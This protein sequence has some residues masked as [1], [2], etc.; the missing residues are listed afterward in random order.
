MPTLICCGREQARVWVRSAGGAPAE[1]PAREPVGKNEIR[2]RIS[3]VPDAELTSSLEAK[4]D[5]LPMKMSEASRPPGVE[6]LSWSSFDPRHADN[7]VTQAW[8]VDIGQPAIA[9]AP[10]FARCCWRKRQPRPERPVG[11]S[12]VKLAARARHLH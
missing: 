7:G 3:V 4:S 10:D 12:R 5:S 9:S 2:Y 8:N 6:L 11:G 1:L